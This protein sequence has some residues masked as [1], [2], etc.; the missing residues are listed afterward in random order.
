[1]SQNPVEKATSL[2]E[3]L[4]QADVNEFPKTANEKKSYFERFNEFDLKFSD[5]PVEMGA[6]KKETEKWK[7]DLADKL[8]KATDAE[9]YD[10][11]KKIID[12]LYKEDTI[13]FLN[14]HGHD[15]VKKVQEKA[16]EILKCFNHSFPTG[17]ETFF[18]LCSISVHDVGN[19][20]GRI[21][22]EKRI[23]HMI[24]TECNN[25]ID[26]SIERRTIARIA[27]VHG[28]NI[29][30]SKDTISVLRI[31]DTINN[32]AVRE[33]ML[34][35]VLRFADELADDRTRAVELA[36]NADVVGKASEIFHVYSS[37]LHTVKLDQNPITKAWMVDLRFSIDEETAKKQFQKGSIQKYLL[38]EIYDRT[39]KMER[40]RRYCMRFLRPY[41]SI[42]SIKVQITI[43]KDDDVFSQE[44]VKYELMEKGYPNSPYGSI[45]DVDS[46]ILTGKEMAEKLSNQN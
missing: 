29:N 12:S 9:K 3:I 30:G 19:L 23:M 20:Y 32:I 6:M 42:E 2:I 27:G 46:T 13:I 28:G 41:C 24:D 33:Q 11:V 43:E 5:T 39:I 34:A 7:N 26:D 4:E 8:K 25:I 37:K 31:T 14:K 17:Y 40:E 16:F 1:M 18:L 38:D 36:L 35:S 10:E 45:K 44:V 22:H 15:H 21:E